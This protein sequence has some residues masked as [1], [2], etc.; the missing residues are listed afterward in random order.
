MAMKCHSLLRSLR[1][2]PFAVLFVAAI[3]F[4]VMS[5][6]NVL[7]PALF[8]LKTIGFW[9]SLGLLLLARILLGGR[10]GSHHWRHRL[11]ERWE[12]MTPEER[13]EFRQGLRARWGHQPPPEPQK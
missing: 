2:L 8:G 13:E 5:L 7:M 3:S 1:I 12:K 6:W 11:M 4:V 9:Q 10:G